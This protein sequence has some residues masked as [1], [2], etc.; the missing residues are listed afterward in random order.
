MRSV[1]CGMARRAHSA[2]RIPRFA[3]DP[4]RRVLVVSHVYL[5]PT[6]RGKLRAF[7]ARDLEVT[8]G[9]PQRWTENAL[10]RSLET[11]WER[12]GGIEIFPIPARQH[13]DPAS[14]RF[15]GRELRSLL[16]DKRPDLVQIEEELLS[17]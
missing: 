2:I 15:G 11:T 6:R 10:G 7:A 5:D 14:L 3:F 4:V 1:E 12:Q 8:L 17:Q 9:V 16:R 13:G